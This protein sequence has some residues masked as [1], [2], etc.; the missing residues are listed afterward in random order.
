[1]QQKQHHEIG[2][3][4]TIDPFIELTIVNKRYIAYEFKIPKPKNI[5]L[6]EKGNNIY[7]EFNKDETRFIDIDDK[8]LNLDFEFVLL[9]EDETERLP[10]RKLFYK[11]KY[12]IENEKYEKSKIKKEELYK[13][14][15]N[16]IKEK[17]KEYYLQISPYGSS[18]GGSNINAESAYRYAAKSLLEKYKSDT[19]I[20]GLLKN[21]INEKDKKFSDLVVKLVQ[22]GKTDV[23]T[24]LMGKKHQIAEIF[25]K[26][27]KEE[28]SEDDNLEDNGLFLKIKKDGEIVKS[29]KDEFTKG[30]NKIKYI[31]H[32]GNKGKEVYLEAL[33]GSQSY[34][35]SI[36]N[37]VKKNK[38]KDI[39]D[40]FFA[41]SLIE[42]ALMDITVVDERV[43]DFYDSDSSV[44]QRFKNQ[45]ISVFE[46][47]EK[48]NEDIKKN[49]DN[50]TEENNNNILIVHQALIKEK[51]DAEEITDK[52]K[53]VF[54]TSGSGGVGNSKN[55]KGGD[56][57]NKARFISFANVR[58]SLMRQYPEKYILVRTLMKTI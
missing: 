27:G 51:E 41:Y 14:W 1:L 8:N 45:N 53:Y 4:I 19:V 30:D 52:F 40:K 22:S 55:E 26:K 12:I 7:K 54:I 44:K 50:K 29:N 24:E 31:R 25:Y 21:F 10:H 46:S 48:L 6:V 17:N 58:S 32:A 9:K 39:N 5:L 13:L 33:S 38:K 36:E 18:T 34:F 57:N 16:K 15:I 3:K 28:K 11:E 42:N 20:I 2:E 37:F 43:H 23:L 35:K 49:K 47:F 56:K